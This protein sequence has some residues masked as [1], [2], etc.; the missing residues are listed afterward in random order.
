MNFYL[1]EY[2][3]NKMVASIHGY[4]YPIKFKKNNEETFFL[5]GAD[6]WG[7]GTWRRAWKEYNNDTKYLINI[8]KN[9]KL[10]REFDFNYSYPYFEMLKLTDK[11]N[12]SWA[13]FKK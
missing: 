4:C 8:I 12:H 13:R 7:W 2:K 1:N 9:K 6:C 11:K 3:T 10:Q 5:K